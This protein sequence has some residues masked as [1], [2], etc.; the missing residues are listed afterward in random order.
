MGVAEH[1][2][3]VLFDFVPDSAALSQFRDE[4][5]QR[6]GDEADDEDK[7]RESQRDVGYGQP[8]CSRITYHIASQPKP[9]RLV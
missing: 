8:E 9:P 4:V 2:T 6:S 5:A 3:E 1:A 7:E